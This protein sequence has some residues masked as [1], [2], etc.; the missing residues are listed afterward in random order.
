M[1]ENSIKKTLERVRKERKDTI[2]K[3]ANS[4]NIP[5]ET[6][7]TF[8]YSKKGSIEIADKILKHYDLKIIEVKN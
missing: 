8:I 5:P 2:E 6:L 4:I 7:R 1:T 3:L